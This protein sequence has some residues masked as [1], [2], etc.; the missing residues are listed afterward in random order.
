MVS[1]LSKP[2]QPDHLP[3]VF[4][5]LQMPQTVQE[6]VA[7]RRGQQILRQGAKLRLDFLIAHGVLVM[8]AMVGDFS[9]IVLTRSR[10]NIDDAQHRFRG[11]AVG[12]FRNTHLDFLHQGEQLRVTPVFLP[13]MVWLD[14]PIHEGYGCGV[15]HAV[16]SG[17][18]VRRMPLLGVTSHNIYRCLQG[19]NG[20]LLD[21][22]DLRELLPHLQDS[23][24]D[25]LRVQPEREVFNTALQDLEGSVTTTKRRQRKRLVA[26]GIEKSSPALEDGRGAGKSLGGKED[27]KD[28]I[29][30]GIGKGAAFPQR[31]VTNARLIQSQVS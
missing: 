15:G 22:F 18:A 7:L 4:Y 29:P 28:G 17:L 19:L 13:K 2:H 27:S 6:S 1:L 9:S 25:G 12:F 10:Q 16:V 14:R 3:D 5:L 21:V 11:A 31:Y 20:N 23:I 30:A 24:R 26:H 8:A